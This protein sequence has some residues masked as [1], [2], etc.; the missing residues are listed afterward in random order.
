MLQGS[1]F[2]LVSKWRKD[3]CHV[4]YRKISSHL[5]MC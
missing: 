1:W 3:L 4:L 2:V 5:I